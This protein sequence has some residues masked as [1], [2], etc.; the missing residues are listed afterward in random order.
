MRFLRWFP[1][2]RWMG[3]L[4]SIMFSAYVDFI[5]HF[6]LHTQY[7]VP[8]GRI[9][10]CCVVTAKTSTCVCKPCVFSHPLREFWMVWD[11]LRKRARQSSEQ[12]LVPRRNPANDA[13]QLRHVPGACMSAPSR[14]WR[15]HQTP[16]CIASTNRT[17]PRIRLQL[18]QAKVT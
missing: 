17:E 16:E 3:A 8:A 5:I 13:P 2:S 1:S 11:F 7:R 18:S 15:L 12:N 10:P 4:L 6:V 9:G 14:H